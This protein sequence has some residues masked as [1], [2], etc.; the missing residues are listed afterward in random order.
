MPVA[1]HEALQAYLT[2]TGGIIPQQYVFDI[3][4]G[5]IRKQFQLPGFQE[6]RK[7]MPDGIFG[8]LPQLRH[9]I[10]EKH[11][12]PYQPQQG[13]CHLMREVYEQGRSAFFYE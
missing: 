5:I 13:Q 4:L 7:V 9:R 8:Q 1:Q 12:V 6:Q 3:M 11:R 10:R 2:I